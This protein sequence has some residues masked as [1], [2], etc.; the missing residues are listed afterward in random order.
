M[1]VISSTQSVRFTTGDALSPSDL[2]DVF[3]YAKDAAADVAEKRFAV[4]A[5][6]LQFT[7]GT[8][9]TSSLGTRTHR[10][11]CPVACTIAR[12]FLDGNITAAAEVTFSIQRADTSA[13]PTGATTPWLHIAAGATTADD[14]NDTSIQAVTLEAGVVYDIIA[15]GTSFMVERLNIVLHVLVDRWR[16]GGALDVPSFAFNDFTDGLADALLVDAAADALTVEAAKFSARSMGPGL[17]LQN[18]AFN[19]ATAAA[20]LLRVLPVP[21]SSRCAS[22]IVRAYLSTSVT[23]VGQVVTALLR[24]ETGATVATL[25]NNH[26]ADLVMTDDSG[27]LAISLN[28]GVETLLEDFTVEFSATTAVTV[29]RAALLLWLEW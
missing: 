5:L 17:A 19:N 15:T 29:T 1:K 10:F 7:P 14:V 25:S 8:I 6:A 11:V 9:N 21:S 16:A 2:N 24:D 28:G 3:L 23:G 13:I 27:A 20:D 22:R 12:A 18:A 26:A 4:A